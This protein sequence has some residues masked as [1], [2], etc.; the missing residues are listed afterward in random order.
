MDVRKFRRVQTC[1]M[2]SQFCLKVLILLGPCE[3]RALPLLGKDAADVCLHV[4]Q[5][6]DM[7]F[8]YLPFL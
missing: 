6:D 7:L 5:F 3:K 2:Q 8:E 1:K 4:F